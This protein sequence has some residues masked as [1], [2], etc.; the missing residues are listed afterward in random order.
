MRLNALVGQ[1]VKH[2]S[3]LQDCQLKAQDRATLKKATS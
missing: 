2:H 3:K 1:M